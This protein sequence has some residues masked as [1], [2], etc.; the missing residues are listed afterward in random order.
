MKTSTKTKA[1]SLAV[2][3]LGALAGP[4]L[5][6]GTSDKESFLNPK[7]IKWG[8]A[9][10]SMPKGA[11]IAVLLGDPGKPGPFVIRLMVPAGYKIA[12][13]WHSQDESLTV[14]SGTLS[15]GMGDK[16]EAGK[17]HALT[18]GG[19]HFLSGRDHHYVTAKTATVIQVSGSG[20]FDM[21]YINP[22]DGPQKAKK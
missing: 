15:F 5:A 1:I 22:D 17:V 13:H 6:Q 2:I 11:K 10:P 18:A 7:D 8:D 9:P 3:I 16:P 19:F 12:P 4:A 21:T 20:P 14:I